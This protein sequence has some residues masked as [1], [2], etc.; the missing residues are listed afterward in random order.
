MATM[1]EQEIARR[2]VG[3]YRADKNGNITQ[4]LAAMRF[5]E[6][7]GSKAIDALN[8]AG[9]TQDQYMSFLNNWQRYEESQGRQFS[10]VVQRVGGLL[11]KEQSPISYAESVGV[12]M[13]GRGEPAPNVGRRGGQGARPDQS[14]VLQGPQPPAGFMRPNEG[15]QAQS[16]LYRNYFAPNAPAGQ[17]DFSVPI[18]SKEEYDRYL[19]G[20]ERVNETRGALGME[21]ISPRSMEDINRGFPTI[22]NV[23]GS[24]PQRVLP[25]GKERSDAVPEMGN[26]GD[27]MAGPP[28]PQDRGPYMPPN[29]GPQ[30][31]SMGPN[32]GPQLP[33]IGAGVVSQTPA[34]QVGQA[35]TQTPAYQSALEGM[36]G[37]APSP[38]MVNAPPVTARSAAPTGRVTSP[39]EG[40]GIGTGAGAVGGGATGGTGGIGG[41]AGRGGAGPQNIFAVQSQAPQQ[42]ASETET[43]RAAMAEAMRTGQPMVLTGSNL[44]VGNQASQAAP[45][46][47]ASANA[48]TFVGGQPQNDTIAGAQQ[49]MFNPMTRQY[50]Q[51]PRGMEQGLSYRAGYNVAAGNPEENYQR[52]LTAMQRMSGMP[53]ARTPAEAAKSMS[54]SSRT[55]MKNNGGE[56]TA[57]GLNASFERYERNQRERMSGIPNTPAVTSQEQQEY[58]QI[59]K[60]VDSFMADVQNLAKL[61]AQN[62]A[63]SNNIKPG[64]IDAKKMEYNINQKLANPEFMQWAG[65]HIFT[66]TNDPNGNYAQK[67]KQGLDATPAEFRLD[68]IFNFFENNKGAGQ[69]SSLPIADTRNNPRGMAA[70]PNQQKYLLCRLHQNGLI[71]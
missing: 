8:K 68:Y 31:P 30:I 2:A 64:S 38:A 15:P 49:M 11:V 7:P 66:I 53:E 4:E 61:Y 16:D 60:Q 57:D 13:T 20:M 9:I 51:S 17:P 43:R 69:Q 28:A 5:G 55:S 10:P 22:Q 56:V 54:L 52:Q 25:T 40:V 29:M 26:F 48:P 45:N 19:Q 70:R 59:T 1:T 47:Q 34:A 12:R 44:Y 41:G 62:R 21:P 71:K 42:Y 27:R 63:E 6:Q 32:D 65:N 24:G 37:Q 39:M 36:M 14:A 58:K 46:S 50:E 67:Y 35:A 18:Y 33:R 3:I 23:T